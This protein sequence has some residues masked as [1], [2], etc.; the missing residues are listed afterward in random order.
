MQVAVS[1]TIASV[2]LRICGSSR[3]STRTSPGAYMTTPRIWLR[4]LTSFGFEGPAAPG[5]MSPWNLRA[6]LRGRAA[7]WGGKRHLPCRRWAAYRDGV[8]NRADIRDFLA[9]RRARLT[10]EQVG[11]PAGSRRRV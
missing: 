3:C 11:L 1:R 2:G 10:P 7:L 5:P 6:A 4:S 8:D 9:T